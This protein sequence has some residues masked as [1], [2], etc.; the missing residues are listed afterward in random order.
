MIVAPIPKNE[1]LRLEAL[2]SYDIL[3]TQPEKSFDDIAKIASYICQ[4][5]IAL[6]VLLDAQ[7]QWFKA[8]VGLDT[9]E[10]SRDSAFCS[11]AILQ[12]ELFIIEDAL[13]DER[14]FDNPLVT[15]DPH[16]RFYAGAPLIDARGLPLG[17]LCVIDRT[18]KTL[19]A[20]QRDSLKALARQV[21]TLLE[22]RRVAKQL[23]DALKEV[24]TLQ[25]LLPI[26]AWCK[27]IHTGD[28]YWQR[29][30]DYLSTH[31]N[32][33]LT[34]GICPSCAGQYFSDSVS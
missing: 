2:K 12:D 14:F 21:V 4:T 28:G 17:T 33:K 10:T 7:R 31:T 27:N 29:M 32:I 25:G 19:S 11:H 30:E 9:S 6:V 16:V 18:T 3:D 8:K 34:H 22:L 20:E 23:A 13:Q 26:C 5:P 15:K 1:D 24:E